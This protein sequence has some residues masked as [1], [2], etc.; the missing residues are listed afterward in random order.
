MSELYVIG[1]GFD[2]HHKL[3]TRYYSYGVYISNKNSE[4]YDHFLKFFGLPDIRDNDAEYLW[5]SF[6]STL[7]ELDSEGALENSSE[8][9]ANPGS[10]DFRDRDWGAF[11]IEIGNFVSTLTEGMKETFVEFIQNV[12]YPACQKLELL[13]LARDAKYINFNYTDTLERY[14]AIKSDHILHIHGKVDDKGSEIVL[15][16]GIGPENF[17]DKPETPPDGLNDEEFEEWKQYQ[18]DKYD[19]SFE[20][21]K[22]ELQSYFESTYKRTDEIITDNDR[23]FLSLNNVQC[24]YVLGHS[25]SHIDIAYF[26]RIFSAVEVEASWK[27]SYY[28]DYEEVGHLSTLVDIGIDKSKIQLFKLEEL[29]A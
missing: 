8:F 21:G 28:N 29:N 9:L 16:H 15:G 11:A 14:Y 17:K 1:N 23:Y 7:S 10:S 19:F 24:V 25:L 13:D 6:E 5:S 3:D 27:V 26:I 18:S 2:I 20:L 12:E 22:D 4:L